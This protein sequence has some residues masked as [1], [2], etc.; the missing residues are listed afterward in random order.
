MFG[1][2]SFTTEHTESTEGMHGR[3]S[4]LCE[5][6]MSFRRSFRPGGRHNPFM[7]KWVWL[8]SLLTF[9]SATV[10]TVYWD[11]LPMVARLG[12]GALCLW[13]F[14]AIG[15]IRSKYGGAT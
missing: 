7:S 3:S 15:Y 2:A 5:P 8:P 9:P 14:G 11:S 10:L 12:L 4:S 13:G 1:S 6:N